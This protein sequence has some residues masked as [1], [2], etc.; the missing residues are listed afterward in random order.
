VL[1]SYYGAL[2]GNKTLR[3]SGPVV[4]DPSVCS[5]RVMKPDGLGTVAKPADTT[6]LA[7]FK[8]PSD[9]GGGPLYSYLNDLTVGA[10]SPF[11]E[12]E[13]MYLLFPAN[14]SGF[15][16]GKRQWAQFD[17][18]SFADD[19]DESEEHTEAFNNLTINPQDWDILKALADSTRTQ[20]SSLPRSDFIDGKG[21]GKYVLLYGPPGVGKSFTVESLANYLH[22]PLLLL[23]VADIGTNQVTAERN[24]SSWLDLAQRWD[25]IV[26]LDEADTYLEKR[27]RGGFLTNTLVAAFL[28]VLEYYPSL[29]FLTTNKPGWLDDAFMSRFHLCVEYPELDQDMRLKVWEKFLYEPWEMPGEVSIKVAKTDQVL[30]YV[31]GDAVTKLSLNGRDIRNAFQAAATLAQFKH[32]AR[33]NLSRSNKP[34]SK[35][36]CVTIDDFKAVIG[37]KIRFLKYM[38][39]AWEADENKRAAFDRS[40]RPA[41]KPEPKGKGPEPEE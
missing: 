13:L 14:I 21:Q 23:T 30:G 32:V 41:K 26:L 38:E 34:I 8:E 11:E 39:D 18:A 25:A 3:Y 31:T 15:A 16:L 33:A 17:V 10:K 36:V 7:K 24:L 12:D 4:V 40:R 2:S 19:K 6:E 5:P 29:I 37:N 1:K 20:E 35:T 28:R 22:R 27:E 9:G